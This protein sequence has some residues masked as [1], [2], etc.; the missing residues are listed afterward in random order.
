MT[1]KDMVKGAPAGAAA[2]ARGSAGERRGKPATPAADAGVNALPQD[3]PPSLD[4]M[5][6]NRLKPQVQP[7]HEEGLKKESSE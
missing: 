6:S 7:T 5:D 4:P 1:N 3:L 2:Q